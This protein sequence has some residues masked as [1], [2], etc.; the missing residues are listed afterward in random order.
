MKE[1][2]N[3][4]ISKIPNCRDFYVIRNFVGFCQIYMGKPNCKVSELTLV[5]SYANWEDCNYAVTKHYENS[6]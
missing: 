2:N 6:I 3:N 4:T 1:P 5:S